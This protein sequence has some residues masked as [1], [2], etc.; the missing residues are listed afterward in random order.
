MFLFK[1]CQ[2]TANDL[3]TDSQLAESV[4]AVIDHDLYQLSFCSLIFLMFGFFS[5]DKIFGVTQRYI[6]IQI[7]IFFTFYISIPEF[8]QMV[9]L[10]SFSLLF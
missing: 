7:L 6:E 8:N 9:S 5:Q 3:E 1:I 10:L 4:K 2:S